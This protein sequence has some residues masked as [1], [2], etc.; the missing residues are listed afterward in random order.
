MDIHI[1]HSL[2]GNVKNDLFSFWNNNRSNEIRSKNFF[3]WRYELRPNNKESSIVFAKNTS[4]EVIGCL[5]IVPHHYYFKNQIITLGVLGD[6]FVRKDY[7]K[8]GIAQEMTRY[9]NTPVL[10]NEFEDYICVS[11]K[12]KTI[13]ERT[14]WSQLGQ[15]R[16]FVKILNISFFF[17]K[18]PRLHFLKAPISKL[19]NFYFIKSI[20]KDKQANA[21]NYSY[22][23]RVDHLHDRFWKLFDKNA[24]L[25]PSKNSSY[26]SWRYLQH[27]IISYN[28][29]YQKYVDEII[30]VLVYHNIGNN[31]IQIDDFMSKAPSKLL[32][33]FFVQ[34]S[35][36]NFNAVQ[37]SLNINSKLVDIVNKLKF[38]S[39]P[40]LQSI[41]G[42]L[43]N[44]KDLELNKIDMHFLAG[45]KDV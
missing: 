20:N 16:R 26:L 23:T 15:L 2:Y 8:N 37:I 32:S 31:I 45:D 38:I 36:Q 22:V 9:L 28:I 35:R 44:K 34:M 18:C 40:D 42:L 14:G 17:Q 4:D 24:K 12:V 13:L 25:M 19:F 10:L 11:N 6:I 33:Q 27:P 3:K 30:G 7:R 43:H 39:R 21:L 1:S 29:C 5:G 41:L